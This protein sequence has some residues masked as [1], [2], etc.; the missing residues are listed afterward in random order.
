MAILN[1]KDYFAQLFKLPLAAGGLFFNNKNE[2]LLLKPTYR[3]GY[4]I[5]GGMVEEQESPLTA[6]KR[7][8]NEEI[9]L[10]IEK[11]DI[12]C[13]DY[14]P[15]NDSYNFDDSSIQIV[16]DCGTLN[17]EQI[18]KIT[19]SEEHSEFKFRSIEEAVKMCNPKL[20]KRLPK[21]IEARKLNRCV[22]LEE[23]KAVS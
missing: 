20:A 11:G 9:G 8:I 13:I 10:Q 23:G 3:D 16:F 15:K 4:L 1:K 21:C 6:L 7:E 19:L 22:Y 12:L 2:I 18:N 17:K 5:P 14:N